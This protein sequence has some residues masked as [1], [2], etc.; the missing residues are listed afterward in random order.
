MS[1]VVSDTG[2]LHY[3]ILC[4]V[5]DILPRLFAKVLIPPAVFKELQHPN[6][7]GKVRTWA[8]E[9]PAWA[10]VQVPAKID[11]TLAVDQGELEA[12]CL[13]REIKAAAILMDDLKGR[14]AAMHCGLRV[15]GTLGILEAA[16]LNGWLDLPAI[17]KQLQTTGARLDAKLIASVLE[18]D[19]QRQKS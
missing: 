11:W 8:Q 14:N 7:P 2:P 9:L 19:R 4:S 17:I 15:T 5:E 10:S 3:L 18:R 16:A 13:A 1:V 12:I 6:A